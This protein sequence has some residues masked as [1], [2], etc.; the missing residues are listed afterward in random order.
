MATST[1]TTTITIQFGESGSDAGYLSAEIDSREKGLNSG[2]TS[3]L[4]EDTAWFL[5]FAG[6]G[7]TYDPPILSD[8]QLLSGQSL[9]IPQEELLT[10]ANSR[11]AKLAKP[12]SGTVSLRWLGRDLG[13]TT[14]GADGMTLT[15]ER[16]GVAVAKVS[17]ASQAR[18]FGV[19]PPKLPKDVFDYSIVAV[20]VGKRSTT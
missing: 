10:F 9:S 8:G 19:K 13:R 16:T 15:S 7:V 5:V 1:V 4:P 18:A 17:Y 2:K 11:E 3:F 14:L 6:P 12:V 20:I